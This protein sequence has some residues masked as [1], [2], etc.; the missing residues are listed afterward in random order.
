MNSF[1]R[2]KQINGSNYVYEITPYYDAEAKTT[3]QRSK[4]LGK[5]TDGKIEEPNKCI[6]VNVY[7]YGQLLPGFKAITDLGLDN[8]LNGLFPEA[9]SKST[10][11]MAI[12]KLIGRDTTKKVNFWYKQTILAKKWGNLSFIAESMGNCLASLGSS[13]IPEYFTEKLL[14]AFEYNEAVFYEITSFN[15]SLNTVNRCWCGSDQN[16][17]AQSINLYLITEKNSGMPL[18]FKMFPGLESDM[19][20][21]NGRTH[22]AD[23]YNVGRTIMSM[24][25]NFFSYTN[26][27]DM[28][29]GGREFVM[30]VPSQYNEVRA[31]ISKHH[32][33]IERT[34]NMRVIDNRTYYV[35]DIKIDFLKL[36]LDGYLFLDPK[37][38]Q[39]ELTEF[40]SNLNMIKE[41]LEKRMTLNSDADVVFSEI[42]GD[43]GRFLSYRVSNNRFIITVK[44]NAV[45]AHVNRFGIIALIHSGR[46]GCEECL[47]MFNDR[48]EL[49]HKF[50]HLRK[51]LKESGIGDRS[52]LVRGMI[53]VEFLAIIMRYHLNKVKEATV[54]YKDCTLESIMDEM[55]GIKAIELMDGTFVITKTSAAQDQIID[56]MKLDI[57]QLSL[58]GSKGSSNCT[59]CQ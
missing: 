36:Q 42:A 19:G 10:V 7:E 20:T 39:K 32:K 28:I 22:L 55:S 56:E 11:V 2:I 6:P 23:E 37:R 47:K 25:H 21:V 35:K 3:K 50:D 48:N 57:S 52:E 54:H 27:L 44:N 41:R 53:F 16:L 31:L 1:T 29:G 5:L 15:S 59:P 30:P 17:D 49:E 46:F 24:H 51:D 38:R 58:I 34:D 18:G 14:D 26:L 40:H 13:N 33:E 4:Y 43:M 8:M 45:S 9:R 12:S